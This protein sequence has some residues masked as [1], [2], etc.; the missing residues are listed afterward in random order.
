LECAN[1]YTKK[2]KKRRSK[3]MDASPDQGIPK[4][5]SDA[6]GAADKEDV[7]TMEDDFADAVPAKV[8]LET[9]EEQEEKYVHLN[10]LQGTGEPFAS[11]LWKFWI[12]EIGPG[13]LEGKILK[14][15]L[16]IAK[17][18]LDL[19]V[20]WQEVN[21][22]G[23]YLDV[24]ANKLWSTVG[25]NFRP[26]PSCTNLSTIVRRV[27]EETLL[28]LEAALK[29]K[30]KV[31]GIE[32]PEPVLQTKETNSGIPVPVKT[33]Q[34]QQSSSQAAKA[35]KLMVKKPPQV[36]GADVIGKQVKVYW[37]KFKKSYYGTILDYDKDQKLHLVSYM[38]GEQKW[39]DFREEKKYSFVRGNEARKVQQQEDSD[40]FGS[41]YETEDAGA[42]ASQG[43]KRGNRGQ[44]SVPL[45]DDSHN[46]T[47]V[48]IRVTNN[49]GPPQVCGISQVEETD[50]GYE[51]Y[52][53][54]PGSCFS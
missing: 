15:P 41:P 13:H 23:G 40:L 51:I 39:T 19:Q 45:V 22:R 34:N 42:G 28:H 53:L 54:L 30:E 29:K 17:K 1:P 4:P 5:S 46:K 37:P 36:H 52:A 50:D 26:P 11:A 9:T 31:V 8:S 27:Y 35:K 12:S 25:R 7:K 16:S 20:L 48:M 6:V 47:G 43:G 49:H 24:K 2:K 3:E 21:K 32:L 10:Q 44:Y 38:D 33:S 18:P 14:C